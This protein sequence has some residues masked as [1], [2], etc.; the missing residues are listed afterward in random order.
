[1]S[2]EG[3]SGGRGVLRALRAT[4]PRRAL[5]DADREL[6]TDWLIANTTNVERFRAG[7]PADWTLADKTGGGSQ[8]GVADDV[9]VVWPSLRPPLVLSVL[10]TKH[11]PRRPLGQP[12][13]GQGGGAG[14]KGTHGTMSTRPRAPEGH[15]ELREQPPPG[16]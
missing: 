2:G 9:G 10:T 7:L 4:P 11:A 1:M 14:G 8:Y 15:G 12:A 6:L 3:P 16:G 5:P 13:G